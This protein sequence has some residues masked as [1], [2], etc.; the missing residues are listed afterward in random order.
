MEQLFTLIPRVMLLDA[1]YDSISFFGDWFWYL[2]CIISTSLICLY[3]AHC[4]KNQEDIVNNIPFARYLYYV[5][6]YFIAM[7]IAGSFTT[8]AWW[9]F[10]PI[11]LLGLF[12]L[13]QW[14]LSKRENVPTKNSSKFSSK[15]ENVDRKKISQTRA[16]SK[17]NNSAKQHSQ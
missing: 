16:A 8:K 13:I 12:V 7:Q 14:T 17:R 4:V 6:Y 9:G 5:F 11:P 15:S 3:F 2:L 10:A 1:R